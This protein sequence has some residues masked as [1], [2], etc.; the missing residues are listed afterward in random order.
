MFAGGRPCSRSH[1]STTAA[2]D[3]IRTLK[4]E[5]KL[6]GPWVDELGRACEEL[7]IPPGASA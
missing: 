6:L 5:G 2:S 1:E 7:Q 3:S 4:L